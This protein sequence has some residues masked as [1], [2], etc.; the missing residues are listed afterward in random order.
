MGAQKDDG[1]VL[2]T[3]L[4]MFGNHISFTEKDRWFHNSTSSSEN[5][6]LGSSALVFHSAAQ[7]LIHCLVKHSYFRPRHGVWWQT[8][9]LRHLQC[10]AHLSQPGACY[11]AIRPPGFANRELRWLLRSPHEWMREYSWALL[12]LPRW[13]FRSGSDA[14]CSECVVYRHLCALPVVEDRS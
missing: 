7:P 2:I 4:W 8:V 10:T 13:H 11:V 1:G 3:S 5:G 12:C 14:T 9:L 6:R